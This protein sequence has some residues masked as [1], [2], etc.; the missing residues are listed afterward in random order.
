[1]VSRGDTEENRRKIAAAG[2]TFPVALQRQWEIS[3]LYGMFATP[4]GYLIDE[5]GVIAADVAQGAE[6]I[7]ALHSRAST[8]SQEEAAPVGT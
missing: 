6:E 4:I 8:P 7:L 3:R 5:R 2:L 1:M